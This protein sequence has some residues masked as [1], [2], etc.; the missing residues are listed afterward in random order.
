M[1]SEEV[2]HLPAYSSAV[3]QPPRRDDKDG[4][5]PQSAA[6]IVIP[7]CQSSDLPQPDAARPRK[8]AIYL[9]FPAFGASLIAVNTYH[10]IN[11]TLG[12]ALTKL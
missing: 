1:G 2:A 10:R 6:I 3:F 4:A 9:H 12:P 11:Q 7:L 8:R 5:S